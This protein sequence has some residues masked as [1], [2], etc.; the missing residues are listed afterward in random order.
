MAIFTCRPCGN[1]HSYQ[2]SKVSYNNGVVIVRCPSCKSLHLVADNL[3][4]FSDEKKNLETISKEHGIHMQKKTGTLEETLESLG[5]SG[6]DAT[7][8][9][10]KKGTRIKLSD[11]VI[12]AIPDEFKDNDSMKKE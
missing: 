5:F 8:I 9:A 10:K 3:K 2:F 7:K 4:W 11:E 6:K 1:R 12:Q